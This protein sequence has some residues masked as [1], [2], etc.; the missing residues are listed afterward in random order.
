MAII[1]NMVSATHEP[2]DT[3]NAFVLLFANTRWTT[4][5]PTEPIGTLMASPTAMPMNRR[6]IATF[7]HD[8]DKKQNRRVLRFHSES[9]CYFSELET[10]SSKSLEMM[11][12]AP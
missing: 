12:C 5:T 7:Y 10:A 6:Y 11:N 2:I 9:H 3:N 4:D 1:P 8:Y